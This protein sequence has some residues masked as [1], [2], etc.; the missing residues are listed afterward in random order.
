MSLTTLL[1]YVGADEADS[2]RIKLAAALADRFDAVLTGMS[3]ETL[4]PPIVIDGTVVD[5]E[6]LQAQIKDL[7]ARLDERGN[8]FRSVAAGERRKLEWRQR[9]DFPADALA[10][11]GRGADLI[12]IGQE[13]GYGGFYRALDAGSAILKA[14]RPVLM[15]PRKVS[16][17]R[18]EHVVV[19][20][21]DTREAR[22]AVYDALPLLRKAARVLVVELSETTE[23]KGTAEEAVTEVVRYLD[24]HRV[25]A[26]SLV[27]VLERGTGAKQLIG[28]AQNEGADL[29][30]AG[31]YGHSRLGEWIFGGMTRG[32][33]AESPMCCLFSH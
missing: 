7:R 6:Q 9:I 32:L 23:E 20:W 31:A 26:D 11:E 10:V 30:V 13:V 1:V 28:L 17:L 3:V 18:A 22:R 25:K 5:G 8:R 15:V 24:R 19:A 33:L 4:P 16:S 27:Q 14:G 12:V 29:I 21:K 2:Q